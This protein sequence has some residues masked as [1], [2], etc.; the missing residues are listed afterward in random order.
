MI[1]VRNLTLKDSFTF[2]F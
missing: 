1:L 2:Y